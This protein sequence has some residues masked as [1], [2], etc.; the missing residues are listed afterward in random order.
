[1]LGKA[2]GGVMNI[3]CCYFLRDV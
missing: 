3:N 2:G 1:M